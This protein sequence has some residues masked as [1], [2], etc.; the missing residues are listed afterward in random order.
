MESHPLVREQVS[1]THWSTIYRPRPSTF[2]IN[3]LGFHSEVK[4][5]HCYLNINLIMIKINYEL[6]KNS[7]HVDFNQIFT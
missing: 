3:I 1:D 7:E 2:R 5:I 6:S 4:Q